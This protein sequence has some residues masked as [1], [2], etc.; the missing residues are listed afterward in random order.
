MIYLSSGDSLVVANPS[1][2]ASKSHVSF[3]DVSGTTLTAGRSNVSSSAASFNATAF[4]AAG[5]RNVR[6]LSVT[7]EGVTAGVF[8]ISHN[9]GTVAV[10][11]FSAV[12]QPSQKLT[13]SE[14]AGFQVSYPEVGLVTTL[15]MPDT[16][17]PAVPAPD[18]GTV[19][20][21]EVAGR[22]MLAQIG[23]SGLDTTLQPN[24]GSNKCAMWMPSG[25]ST[26]A[27]GVFG[28]A[29]LTAV[30]TAT[31][32]SITVSNLLTRMTRLG[33]VS[34]ATAGQL[35]GAREALG[36]FTVGAG[37]GLGGFFIRYR[38]GVSDAATVAGARMFVGLSAATA[39][40]TNVE[41]TSLLNCVGVAQLSS[42]TNLQLVYANGAVKPAIDLGSNFPAN[43]TADA[44]ELV[45]FAPNAGGVYYQVTRLNTPYMTQGFLPS[46]DTP[47]AS[48]LLCHQL[49]RCN[50]TTALAVGLDICSIYAETDY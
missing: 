25:G 45:L 44:Y 7:N 49:W 40:P 2:L 3:A 31:T 27:P 46:T 36:K 33:F 23:P 35:A 12:L 24:L 20:F 4:A 26:T 8:T 5:T 48:T 19:F 29:A 11:L 38:F 6:V 1:T 47:L 37:G 41:P 14:A 50:N 30:G 21:K 22:M 17:V 42:S 16:Q 34:A 13:Y 32:R 43:S 39:A 10:P 28:M 9:D 18:T 15:T